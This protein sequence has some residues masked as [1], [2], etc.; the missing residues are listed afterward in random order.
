MFDE[1]VSS[2]SEVFGGKAAGV[3][4]PTP[5]EQEQREYEREEFKRR[6][7]GSNN[8]FNREDTN[9]KIFGSSWNKKTKVNNMIPK[10]KG[11]G[12]K[13]MIPESTGMGF[14]DMMP[15]IKLS[16]NTSPSLNMRKSKKGS[17]KLVP[18]LGGGNFKAMIPQMGSNK[19]I[20]FKGMV[21][22]MNFKSIASK[23]EQRMKQQVGLSMFG[24]YDKDGV[25]NILDCNPRNRLR[26][27]IATKIKN[28][29]AGRGFVED[30]E[31]PLQTPGGDLEKYT[32]SSKANESG[33]LPMVE[34]GA[35][36]K[37][38]LQKAG[39]YIGEGAKKVGGYLGGVSESAKKVGGYVGVGA[40]GI[41][42]GVSNVY[43]ATGLPDVKEDRE[44]RRKWESEIRGKAFKEATKDKAIA[45]AQSLY[46]KTY[47]KER[48]IKQ[49]PTQIVKGHRSEFRG[50]GVGMRQAV[51]PFSIGGVSLGSESEKVS[52]L[53][54]LKSNIGMGAAMQMGGGYKQPDP[55]AVKVDE[56]VGKGQLRGMMTFQPTAPISQPT[57]QYP[58]TQTPSYQS[59]PRGLP[60]APGMQ[61]SPH[62][63][64]WVRY[65]RGPYKK[66][67]TYGQ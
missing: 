28:W 45:D 41:A 31:V 27:G 23:P 52:S 32:E 49:T 8:I 64:R 30:D 3:N 51:T 42:K 16:G 59:A 58:T 48:G 19:G 35:D 63:K 33:T 40:S 50:A 15:D 20:S 14:K 21:P 10:I 57:Q 67:L 62:S 39:G 17:K 13:D 25:A 53:I 26:Q 61:W 18:S 4:L 34:Y 2:L 12:I 24:D 37:S 54:G 46:V 56:A 6:N 55:F 22:E 9:D 65:P 36:E 7:V 66:T 29:T 43:Q 60:P 5:E 11:T 47:K 1:K 44:Q 38:S